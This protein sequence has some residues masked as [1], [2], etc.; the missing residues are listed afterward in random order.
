M[1]LHELLNEAPLPD[2]WDKS[3]YKSDTSF[4]SRLRYAQ[5]R[6]KKIGTGSSRVAFEIEY[7]GRPTILKI[8][9]NKKGIAQNDYES[10]M[11]NDYYVVGMGITIPMID[12]DEENE[13]PTWIHTEKAEKMKPTQFKKFFSGLTPD[14]LITVINYGTGRSNM[15]SPEETERMQEII[16]NN[17]DIDSLVDLV[18]NYGLPV[19]D[20][21][22]L[23]NWGIYNGQP[24]IIDLG[25]SS[26]V[27]AQHYS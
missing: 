24:V 21:S 19:G 16:E 26:D 10:Q 8:A 23:A 13:P 9:K 17:E 20:F 11:F 12:H 3:A 15:S 6:A 1:K 18:G 5:E 14:E 2:D 7:Q 27:M 4:A 25:L 22:R